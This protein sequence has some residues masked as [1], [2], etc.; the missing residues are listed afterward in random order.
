MITEKS[1]PRKSLIKIQSIKFC[2]DPRVCALLSE[3]NI[4]YEIGR[5]SIADIDINDV[6]CQ[7]RL[8][9][10]EANI[11][12]V[13]RYLESMIFG[14][15]FPMT[16]LARRRDKRFRI[17]CGNHRIRAIS[18]DGF[19]GT[20]EA[21]IIPPDVDKETLCVIA[22][23]DNVS[24]GDKTSGQES[25]AIA[26]KMLVD[27]PLHDGESLQSYAVIKS[28]STKMR[29]PVDRLKDNYKAAMMR[30]II[31]RAGMNIPAG[32]KHHHNVNVLV[33]LWGIW[34]RTKYEPL[35]KSVARSLL[36]DVSDFKILELLNS[37]RPIQDL[38]SLIDGLIPVESETFQRP[39]VDITGRIL[40]ALELVRNSIQH[41]PH[42]GNVTQEKALEIF[43]LSKANADAL[44]KWSERS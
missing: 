30:N 9:V 16:V 2:E 20:F 24:H 1:G 43:N 21:I 41:L 37:K 34:D 36:K 15:S 14:D 27:M 31:K 33:K 29:L 32:T 25:V 19:N 7:T 40:G 3:L 10:G 4:P 5:L 12:S 13:Q 28:I 22:T 38:P 35:I 23:R 26:V 42:R 11:E 39:R 6:E 44:R 17:V 8:N 18:L